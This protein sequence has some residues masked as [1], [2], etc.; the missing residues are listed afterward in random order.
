MTRAQVIAQ[1]RNMGVKVENGRVRKSDLKR[2]LGSHPME[3]LKDWSRKPERIGDVNTVI[4]SDYPGLKDL[5]EFNSKDVLGKFLL[6]EFKKPMPQYFILHHSN[7]HN[8]VVNTEGYD[9]PRYIAEIEDDGKVQASGKGTSDID[10]PQKD[11]FLEKMEQAATELHDLQI[12]LGRFGMA[13][14][15]V[16]QI[17]EKHDPSG[18]EKQGLKEIKTWYQSVRDL[19]IQ[20]EEKLQEVTEACKTDRKS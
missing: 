14:T 10:A 18:F 1:L 17:A 11:K 6:D 20:I 5:P 4:P 12:K 2:V 8:Y 13:I 3:K 19:T 16:D 15:Q 9:Y 7:G